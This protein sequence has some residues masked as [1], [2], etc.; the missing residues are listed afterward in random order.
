MRFHFA[1]H[2]WPCRC[3]AFASLERLQ[4]ARH[5][6]TH[7]QRYIFIGAITMSAANALDRPSCFPS[8]LVLALPFSRVPI[9]CICKSILNPFSLVHSNHNYQCRRVPQFQ[10]LITFEWRSSRLDFCKS[11]PLASDWIRASIHMQMWRGDWKK[12]TGQE[13][14]KRNF[15]GCPRFPVQGVRVLSKIDTFP[16]MVFTFSIQERRQGRRK[17]RDVAVQVVYRPSRKRRWIFLVVWQ[18]DTQHMALD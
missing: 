3:T 2:S 9:V 4:H 15:F 7:R 11:I 13:R 1:R 10:S 12:K 18:I 5:T 16:S 17:K 8:H 14:N 6:H